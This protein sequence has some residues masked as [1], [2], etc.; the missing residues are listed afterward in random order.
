M[1]SGANIMDELI[2]RLDEIKGGLIELRGY[3]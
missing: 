2:K 1:F 3:L